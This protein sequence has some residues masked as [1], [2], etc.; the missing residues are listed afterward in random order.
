MPQRDR[1]TYRGAVTERRSRMVLRYFTAGETGQG[2]DDVRA[3]KM[4][5]KRAAR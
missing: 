2:R 3:R 4:R 5:A 1:S